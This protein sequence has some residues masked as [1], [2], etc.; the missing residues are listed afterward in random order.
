M[1][2]NFSFMYSALC[3]ILKLSISILVTQRFLF[4]INL[5][6]VKMAQKNI[7]DEVSSLC[8]LLSAAKLHHNFLI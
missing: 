6:S 7:K 5:K 4:R 2:H 8:I 1:T 3:I